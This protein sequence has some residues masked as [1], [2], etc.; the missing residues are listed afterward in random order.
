MIACENSGHKI[1]DDF[2]EARKIVEAGVTTKP[3][4]DYELSK[5]ACYLIVQNGGRVHQRTVKGPSGIAG[6][7]SPK[8]MA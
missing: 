8:I 1:S 5:Y 2:P 6:R 4:K 7:H 3:R